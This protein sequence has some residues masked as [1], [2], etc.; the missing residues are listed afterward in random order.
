MTPSVPET[1]EPF[2]VSPGPQGF[3][4]R[5]LILFIVLLIAFA[6]ACNRASNVTKEAI[7]V[8]APQMNLRD[9]L[10]P[11]YEKKG[12]VHNG[13]KV[14]VL[15][16]KKR[17]LRVRTTTGDEGWIEERYTIPAAT[18]EQ[19]EKLS[20][21]NAS[22]PVQA[23]G[24]ARNSLNLHLTPGRDTDHLYQVKEGEKL[25]ILKRATAEKPGSAPAPMVQPASMKKNAPP[26]GPVLEDWWLVRDSE[27]HAG[28]V[29]ARM[30]DIDVPMDIAQYAEGQRI[31]AFFVLNEVQDQDKKVPQYLAL[32]TENKD[33]LPYDFSI[34][35][36]FTWNLKKHR[37]ETAYRERNLNGVFPIKTGNEDFGKEGNLPIFVLTVL[38]DQNQPIERK[39][40]MAGVMVKRVLSAED[41]QKQADLKAST[42]G[43]R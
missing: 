35:R 20:A 32:M 36:V 1:S 40:R 37:Y 3:A 13:E 21:E 30:V 25:D 29:L 9:R 5:L 28:W 24:S 15:E 19:F 16:K 7:Y 42:K 6:T 12:L 27:K 38:N 34:A 10:A 14:Y 11:I 8:T 31:V 4:P 33:G 41:E 17:F 43:R 23:H 2:Q 39:Y 18:Y 22:T 26:P